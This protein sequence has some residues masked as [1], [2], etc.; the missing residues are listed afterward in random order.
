MTKQLAFCFSISKANANHKEIMEIS[1][2]LIE[3]I[4]EIDGVELSKD[5]ESKSSVENLHK[6]VVNVLNVKALDSIGKAIISWSLRDRSRTLS[7]Q[8]G[9][10]QLDVSGLSK[11]EQQELINWFQIQAGMTFR[12]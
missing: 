9:S 10:N 1:H 3:K 8:I 5:T 2:E 12:K 11:D 7:L 6:F 4:R